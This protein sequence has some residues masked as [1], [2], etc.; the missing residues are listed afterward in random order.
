MK[1]TQIEILSDYIK[2]FN[3]MINA[4]SQ[5]VHQYGKI[6]FMNIRAWLELFKDATAGKIT[7]NS[8]NGQ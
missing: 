8:T 1:R 3:I 2:G 7:K 4:S 6:E 5:L